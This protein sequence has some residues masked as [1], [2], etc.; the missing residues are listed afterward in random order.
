MPDL[1]DDTDVCYELAVSEDDRIYQLRIRCDLPMSREEYAVCLKSLAEDIFA[2]R[3]IDVLAGDEQ[4][5]L[6]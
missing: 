6:N 3:I 4:S 1:K 2:G 5:P